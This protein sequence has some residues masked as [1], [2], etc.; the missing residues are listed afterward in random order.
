MR[1]EINGFLSDLEILLCLRGTFLTAWP[2]CI[3]NGL[4]YWKCFRKKKNKIRIQSG[5]VGQKTGRGF[6]VPNGED[7][8]AHQTLLI[9]VEKCTFVEKTCLS[10]SCY[11]QNEIMGNASR[12]SCS[13]RLMLRG[14]L[15]CGL[16]C[17][18]TSRRM[19]WLPAFSTRCLL[20]SATC[21]FAG[22]GV[23]VGG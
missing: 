2:C 5:R 23:A 7:R 8:V 17:V 4:E 15:S 12:R 6:W 21:L 22:T 16:G 9:P 1:I 3:Q 20:R 18:A 10:L 19:S 11:V 13:S 14:I